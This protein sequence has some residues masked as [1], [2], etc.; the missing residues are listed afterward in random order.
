[1]AQGD[2]SSSSCGA[3]TQPS[4]EEEASY[5]LAAFSTPWLET[6]EKPADGLLLDGQAP[7]PIVDPRKYKT[8]LCRTWEA[9]GSCPYEH[10]C[11]FAHGS[12]ELRNLA[13][14]HKTLASIGY[15]SNVMLL[16][17]SNRPKPALPPH[18]LYQQPPVFQR[19][20]SAK[21]LQRCTKALPPG[22]RFP[23]Q[24]LLPSA[25]EALK[26][27]ARVQG[28][29]QGPKKRR[30]RGRRSTSDLHST[31]GEGEGNAVGLQGVPHE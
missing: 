31:P 26:E 23:F 22:V 12:A 18:W 2:V 19:P 24:H 3:S 5:Q 11:C 14:N 28:P 29:V 20:Q 30:R 7:V 13:E 21:Q 16:A 9:V 17:M 4:S 8:K 15:F 6:S 27:E 1:M 10:T 25:V